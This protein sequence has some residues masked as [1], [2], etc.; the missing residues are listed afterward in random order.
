MLWRKPAASATL[1]WASPTWPTAPQT[2]HPV[3]RTPARREREE[4]TGDFKDILMAHK[5]FKLNVTFSH[6]V[7]TVGALGIYV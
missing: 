5:S 1:G 7:C 3:P 2:P 6:T 4:I